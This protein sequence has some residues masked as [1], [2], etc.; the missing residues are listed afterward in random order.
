MAQ[1]KPLHPQVT[2]EQIQLWEADPVTKAYLQCL[3]WFN[4]DVRD[5]ASDGTIIDSACADLSHARIHINLGQQQGLVTAMEYGK[6]FNDFNM[7]FKE[8]KTDD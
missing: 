5:D 8:E 6:L 1:E 3:E 4:A 2:P 7:I